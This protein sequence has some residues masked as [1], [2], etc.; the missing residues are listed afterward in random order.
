[1]FIE[2]AK[3]NDRFSVVLTDIVT[4][5]TLAEFDSEKDAEAHALKTAQTVFGSDIYEFYANQ[6]RVFQKRRTVVYN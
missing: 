4:A 6:K 1:M 3:N 2:L 5:K